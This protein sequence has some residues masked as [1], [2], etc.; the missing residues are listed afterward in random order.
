MPILAKDAEKQKE[1][2]AKATADALIASTRTSP[3]LAKS[4][5]G[6]P[7]MAN[8]SSFAN[9]RAANAVLSPTSA[10]ARAAGKIP[11]AIQDIPPFNPQAKSAKGLAPAGAV[12]A[13]PPSPAFSA[14]SQASARLNINA[15]AFVFKPNPNASAFRPSLPPVAAKSPPVREIVSARVKTS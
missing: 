11:M 12:P 2:V 4:T 13:G 7:A 8:A 1:I 6:A 3:V 5:V 10:A 9:R 15:P 14:A